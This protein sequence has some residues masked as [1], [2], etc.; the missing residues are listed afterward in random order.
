M[1]ALAQDVLTSM[2]QDFAS[3]EMRHVASKPRSMVS[4][5][6]KRHLQ[7]GRA[8]VGVFPVTDGRY[9]MQIYAGFG[10]PEAFFPVRRASDLKWLRWD[11]RLQVLHVHWDERLTGRK[12]IDEQAQ[13][14][15]V[16]IRDLEALLRRGV[17]L[18]F[19]AHNATP[20]EGGDVAAFE[21]V[22]RFLVAHATLLH[23]HSDAGKRLLVERFGADPAKVVIIQHPSYVG[24]HAPA[25]DLSATQKRKFLSIGSIRKYKGHDAMIQGFAAMTR[26]AEVGGLTIR[27][28]SSRGLSIDTAPLD[29]RIEVTSDLTP[30]PDH[31]MAEVFAEHDFVV[32]SYTASLTSG[33]AMLAMTFGTP[34]IAPDLGGI[35][36]MLGAELD[37]FLFTPNDP[38]AMGQA[39]DRA[40]ALSDRE[41]QDLREKALRRADALNPAQQSRQL[42]R[43]FEERGLWH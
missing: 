5:L 22:R 43:A 23:V 15:D 25:K 3:W 7:Y 20:H 12:T 28:A 1:S 9:F 34:V 32:M 42:K 19:T 31:A 18:V 29:G 24:I 35:R 4:R 21:R 39:L 38:E 36:E 30:V 40:V 16:V 10:R 13:Q 37:M 6:L 8:S 2:E 41:L 11:A 33:V 17:K 14:A 26:H 27:G